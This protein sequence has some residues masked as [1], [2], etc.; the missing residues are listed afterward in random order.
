MN[1]ISLSEGTVTDTIVRVYSTIPVVCVQGKSACSLEFQM[2]TIDLAGNEDL[3]RVAACSNNVCK[4]S[5]CRSVMKNT[6][7]TF[8]SNTNASW[9]I[10]PTIDTENILQK[11]IAQFQIT[12]SANDNVNGAFWNSV[13]S[14]KINVN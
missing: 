14:P 7:K 4:I 1:K 8:D 9:A 6:D 12:V 11:K 13:A 5:G 2:T 3:I 10:I